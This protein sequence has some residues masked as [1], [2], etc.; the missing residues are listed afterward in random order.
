MKHL[1][2]YEREQ[3]ALGIAEKL[4]RRRIAERINRHHATIVRELNNNVRWPC[5][6]SPYDANE[7]A[8]ELKKK[9]KRIGKIDECLEL[10]EYIFEKL[11]LKWSPEQISNTLKIKHKNRNNMQISHESIYTYIYLLPRG[12]LRK[13]LISYL[14]Q[15][16]KGRQKRKRGY[17]NR[18][19]KIPNLIS[20]KERPEEVENRIIPGHWESDLIIGK[21]KQS[22][23]GTVVERTTRTTILVP[24]KSKTAPEVRQSFAKELKTLPKQMIKSITHDRG[25]EMQQHE[26]F[27]ENTQI[28]VYFA[29]PHSPWQRGTNEN[30]NGLLRQYF[31]KGTDFRKISR[32]EIKKV[33]NEL[34][35]RPRK[36]LKWH[37]PK[38]TF[39]K[40]LRNGAIRV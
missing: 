21:D 31:P 19:Q 4:S 13:E 5:K 6:Y 37:T 11:K 8:N 29:D 39:A 7:K 16:T 25:N 15:G 35:E 9:S 12:E 30:T 17:D 34:N 18:Q 10:R 23:L 33:Q 1:N 36:I 26:L 20:I 22:A 2:M 28:K 3:I 14:R 27:T 24:L 38:E 32:K 40:L